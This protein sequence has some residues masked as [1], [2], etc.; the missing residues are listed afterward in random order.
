MSSAVP[1]EFRVSHPTS[2]SR[3]ESLVSFT[4]SHGSDV[5]IPA[6]LR[7]D[8]LCRL[9]DHKSSEDTEDIV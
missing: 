3:L 6:R 2:G 8:G 9:E 4:A 7:G 5:K 1:S